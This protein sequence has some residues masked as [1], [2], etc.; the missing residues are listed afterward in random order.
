[1]FTSGSF[2]ALMVQPSV[3]EHSSF[4]IEATD[5]SLKPSSRCWMK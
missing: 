5:L 2:F 3:R 1:M 4:R